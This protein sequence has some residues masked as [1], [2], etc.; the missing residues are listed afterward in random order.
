MRVG[1][2][3]VQRQLDAADVVVGSDPGTH[4]KV[5][6]VRRG[7][8]MTFTVELAPVPSTEEGS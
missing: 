1:D 7:V 8:P 5:E 2:R 6:I 4:V 3:R